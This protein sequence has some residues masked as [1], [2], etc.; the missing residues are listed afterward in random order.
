MKKGKTFDAKN[1][2]DLRQKKDPDLAAWCAA[3]ASPIIEDT[4]PPG[5][6]TARELAK[7]LGKAEST[8]GKLLNRAVLDGRA[9]KQ[10]FRITSGQ[11]TRPVPHYRLK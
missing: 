11:V 6:M 4:V 8:M 7:K 2:H 5:W 1:T 10:S 3:L 9:E